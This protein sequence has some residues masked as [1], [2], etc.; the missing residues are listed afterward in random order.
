MDALSINSSVGA[1]T[2]VLKESGN[3]REKMLEEMMTSLPTQQETSSP[4]VSGLAAEGIGSNLDLK[5]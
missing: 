3:V 4:S 2:Y 1:G 5:A